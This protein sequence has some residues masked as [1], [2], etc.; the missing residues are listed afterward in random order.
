MTNIL[1]KLSDI[2]Q[3]IPYDSINEKEKHQIK[4]VILDRFGCSLGARRLGIGDNLIKYLSKTKSTKQASIW[5]SYEKAP[6]HYAALANGTISSH[7]EFDSHDSMIPSAIALGES[8]KINGKKLMTSI[9]TGYIV[10]SIVKKLLASELEKKGLHWPAHISSFFSAAASSKILD[11][12][13]EKTSAALSIVGSLNP[14][15]PFECFTQGANVKDLYGG[16]GNML[17]I[18]ATELSSIG[19]K[20]PNTIFEGER[21]LGKIWLGNSLLSERVKTAFQILED[22]EMKFRIK[23]YPCCTAAH[24]A[25]TVL[26]NIINEYPNLDIND[27]IRIQINTYVYGASLSNSSKPNTTISAKIN[28]PFLTAVMLSFGELRPEYTEHPYIDNLTLLRLA[29]KI[30]VSPIRELDD[31]LHMRRR[32]AQVKIYLKNGPTIKDSV[33]EPKWALN[34]P[35]SDREVIQKFDSLVGNFITKE[36]HKKLVEMIFKIDQIN[37]ITKIV[38]L[39]TP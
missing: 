8:Q 30:N 22:H 11:F 2:S 31:S 24:P 29:K 26:E 15:S 14:I 10:G 1:E 6:I 32:P 21:G 7:L 28:I 12:D 27:I 3:S 13:K 4:R 38:Q 9:K 19:I 33:N 20:G 25:L 37:D 39:L 18:L 16:W 35:A 36:K 5:G 23:P 17:G 34:N